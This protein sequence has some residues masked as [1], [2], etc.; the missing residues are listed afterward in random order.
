MARMKPFAMRIIV[1]DPETA[2]QFLEGCI[3]ASQNNNSS[4]FR[5]LIDGLNA[6]MREYNKERIAEEDAIPA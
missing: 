5:E 1:R 2:Q 4:Y 3:L 6:G